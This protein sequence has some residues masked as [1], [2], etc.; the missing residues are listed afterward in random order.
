MTDLIED[1]PFTK[2]DIIHIQNP[3]DMKK[4]SLSHFIRLKDD[5]E[6]KGKK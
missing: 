5:D 6:D 3:N 1:D 2:A 4:R